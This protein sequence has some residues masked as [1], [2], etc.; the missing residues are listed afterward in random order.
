M[1]QNWW[2][3]IFGYGSGNGIVID[4]SKDPV[5][6]YL[7]VEENRSRL[8][9]VSLKVEQ[10]YTEKNETKI[11]TFVSYDH[12]G[13]HY[14]LFVKAVDQKDAFLNAK[15]R[16]EAF[17]NTE[18]GKKQISAAHEREH[19]RYWSSRKQELRDKPATRGDIEALIEAVQGLKGHIPVNVS[20]G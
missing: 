20:S 6:W 1:Y 7:C 15:A 11:D 13:L 12:G 3:Q 5:W 9:A 17:K 19:E 2:K 8:E 10:P 16:I 4:Q 18:E 14:L